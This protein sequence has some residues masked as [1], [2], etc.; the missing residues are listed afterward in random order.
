MRPLPALPPLL[1]VCGALVLGCAFGPERHDLWPLML[2]LAFGAAVCAAL[3]RT[4][5]AW[6]AAVALVALA[7]GLWRAAPPP[8]H[9]T[10]WPAMPVNA[11]RGVATTWP[12]VHG[13]S[14]LVAVEADG[15][16]TTRAW[17]PARATL[18]AFLPPYPVVARGDTVIVVGTPV[19]HPAGSA[20]TDGL[21]FGQ[22]LRV[23]RADQPTDADTG[24]KTLRDRLVAGI[25]AHVRAPEA[26]FAA[27]VLLGEKSAIDNTTHAA[28]NAT[29]TT[30]HCV[31][32][33]RRTAGVPYPALDK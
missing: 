11:V 13:E 32:T 5:A 22:S 25:A 21:L 30:Q 28:L 12:V 26:G 10:L 33:Q 17:E 31:V 7:F 23:A 2:G 14:V 15:A 29:G 8:S 4:A 27:G 1:P 19:L 24:R 6:V 18:T 9:T 16:R 20:E 3:A